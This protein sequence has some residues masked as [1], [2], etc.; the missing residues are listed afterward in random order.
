MNHITKMEIMGSHIMDMQNVDYLNFALYI[1][2]LFNLKLIHFSFV[3]Y[4][5]NRQSLY[6]FKNN[7]KQRVSQSRGALLKR[8]FLFSLLCI[9]FI[10][11]F[12]NITR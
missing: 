7:S 10:V 8:S 12:I 3:V 4:K 6:L 2:R 5:Y 11:I 1:N 9:V